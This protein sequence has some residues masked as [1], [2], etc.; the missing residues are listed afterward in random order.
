[1]PDDIGPTTDPIR[2][3]AQ[4][5]AHILHIIERFRRGG[6][7]HALTGL[8]KYSRRA[9]GYEHRV[10]SL[11]PSDPLANAR[12]ADTGLVVVDHL[13][14]TALRAEIMQADVVHFHF[15]NSAELH[16]LLA[17]NLP[18]MRAV[19]WCHVNGETAPQ[20]LPR[21]L[22][23]FADVLVT[24]AQS[25]LLLPAFRSA[26]TDRIECIPGG[27]DFA[28]LNGVRKTAHAGFNVGYIGR[29]DFIKLHPDFCADVCRGS[30]PDIHFYVCGDGGSREQ[31]QRQAGEMGVAD[32][33]T[34]RDY[35]RDIRPA[36]SALDVFGYPLCEGNYTTAELILQE[37]MYLGVPPVVMPYGGAA[38]LV[39]HGYS[40][41]V[42]R[43]EVDYVQALEWLYRRPD[44]RLR[45]GRNASQEAR[46]RSGAE[47]C[48]ARFDALY[49][50]LMRQP[51]LTRSTG[52][53][54][55]LL[56][57]GGARALI[58]SLDG[59]DDRNF[60]ASLN[61]TDGDAIVDRRIA[62][63]PPGMGD[64]SCNTACAIRTMAICGC[65]RVWCSNKEAAWHW[66]HRSSR[67]AWRAAADR[68]AS[69][70]IL[71]VQFGKQ[72][73]VSTWE[74][75]KAPKRTT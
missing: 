59:V 75:R 26:D 15:W 19:V 24:T 3:S 25:T 34:F 31:L 73:R 54:D 67:Q 11:L 63:G 40:G 35:L 55:G 30:I 13:D 17:S 7:A 64:S 65:G 69:V 8:A 6:P 22:L 29:V 46:A 45:L 41:I 44:E 71:P 18:P 74:S 56:A 39:R 38:T 51:K 36:V 20:I 47:K 60:I 62:E 2:L 72:H 14:A 49:A 52:A 48:A 57:N 5:A 32:R 37:V 43:N 66:P 70:T 21:W 42:A 50:R 1:M 10:V 28:Q 53:E 61:A 58:R 27:T 16:A 12:T 33:F 68:L 23:P 4:P 9:C